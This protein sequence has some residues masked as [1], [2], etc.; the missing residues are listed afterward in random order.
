MSKWCICCN[1]SIF[2]I[3]NAVN[4]N[5][6]IYLKRNVG[7]VQGDIIYIYV[8]RPCSKIMYKA[9]AEK[10][11]CSKECMME[12][13]AYLT[14]PYEELKEGEYLRLRI[15]GEF[16]GDETSYRTVL[17]N[18]LN[19]IQGPSRVKEQLEE[20]LNLVENNSSYKEMK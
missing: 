9:I 19:T 18:G 5:K 14:V 12:L 13:D 15:L 8:S 4:D 11:D 6:D 10:V 16:S 20:Y 1:I 3:I 2:N 17:E 7:I